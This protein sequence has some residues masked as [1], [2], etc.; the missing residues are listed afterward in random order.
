MGYPPCTTV[1]ANTKLG[2][3]GGY[4]PRKGNGKGKERASEKEAEGPLPLHSRPQTLWTGAAH[5]ALA[6]QRCVFG[7][8]YRAPLSIATA[9]L[10]PSIPPL[11]FALSGPAKRRAGNGGL[12]AVFLM[13]ELKRICVVFSL[14][15]SQMHFCC[16]PPSHVQRALPWHAFSLCLLLPSPLPAHPRF[17]LSPFLPCMGGC[18][19]LCVCCVFECLLTFSYWGMLF[20]WLFVSP[21]DLGISNAI[22]GC[23]LPPP[24]LTCFSHVILEVHDKGWGA[25]GRYEI[26]PICVYCPSFAARAPLSPSLSLAPSPPLVSLPCRHR[27]CG[28]PQMNAVGVP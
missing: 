10:T 6:R 25:A 8:L 16:F 11:Q 26:V 20:V 9:C 28:P 17:L 21:L 5:L 4:E 13:P 12:A 7:C 14:R 24:V 15:T 19:S 18:L 3:T 23:F 27:H 2:G 22:F 1:M